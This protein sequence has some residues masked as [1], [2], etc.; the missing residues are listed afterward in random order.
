MAKKLDFVIPAVGGVTGANLSACLGN[1][2]L[3]GGFGGISVGLVGMTGIGILTSSA[4]YASLQGLETNDHNVGLALGIGSL[5]GIGIY[6]TFGGVGVAVKG[7]AFGVGVGSIAIAGGLVGLGIYGLMKMLSP[8]YSN[9]NFYSNLEFFDRITREYEEAL[10]WQEVTR[11]YENLE[12]ELQRLLEEVSVQENQQLY[13]TE[14]TIPERLSWQCF[15]TLKG[16]QANIG[17]IDV[18]PDG[19]IIASAGEDQTIK[20]W[21]RETG[22]LIYSFVG[23]NEPLQTL[24]ISP[25]GKSIIAGGLDGRISQWQLDTKQ[26]KSSFFARVNA[27]DSHDGVI[28]Q[29]AFAANERFIVSAS[30]DK[31]LRIWGYHTGE[32]KRTL[33]GH[34]EA[35]NTCAIS[36]DSQIIASGSDDK[37]IKLWRF[38]HSYAYQTFIGDRA[39]VNSLAFSNDG[40]YLISGGSDKVIKIWDIKT[41]EIIKSWQAHE[42]AIISIAINPHRHLIA[43]ASRTEIKIWQGQTGE[44]IKILRGTAPLK[45]SPDGQFLITGS[46]GHKVKIWSEML[47]EL[48]ILPPDSEDWWEVLE[49][50]KNASFSEVKQRYYKLARQYH[51]D[52]N[53]SAMAIKI[54]QKINRAYER[55]LFSISQQ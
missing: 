28:L 19:K 17:A 30:N 5:G 13:S 12:V 27:P 10:F 18:S 6:S 53:S 50:S 54:M 20:L 36:P 35:V 16:H 23:V 24:A 39:A 48:E 8:T 2:G 7:T 31:T 21:Q 40:Q 22:K 33:I 38:D 1:I 4:I 3:V 52:H 44:L 46:Y 32:L 34:E 26:Y 9:D 15:Q 11:K 55:F 43:S 45:F 47:G 42:Q 29:L 49:I 51:P 37:T 25:N 41:G 14:I